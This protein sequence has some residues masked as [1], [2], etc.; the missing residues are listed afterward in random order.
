MPTTYSRIRSASEHW[1]R[2]G[3]IYDRE[4]Q[5]LSICPQVLPV[6]A[7]ALFA[8]LEGRFTSAAALQQAKGA[9][10]G[11]LSS[12]DPMSYPCWILMIEGLEVAGYVFFDPQR[13]YVSLEFIWKGAKLPAE[14]KRDA[15][16]CK[17]LLSGVEFRSA[18]IC[19]FSTSPP[20]RGP[21]GYFWDEDAVV[22]APAEWTG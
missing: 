4:L 16:I 20:D 11:Y 6:A 19:G 14:C 10:L 3:D 18:P 9:I 1:T 2:Q 22:F 7:A 13:K 8:R 21:D 12:N 15:E 17:A 5:I